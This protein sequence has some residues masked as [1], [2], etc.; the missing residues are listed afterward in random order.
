MSLEELD[1]VLCIAVQDAVARLNKDVRTLTF[2]HTIRTF[3]PRHATFKLYSIVIF[4][5]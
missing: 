4:I 5:P 3:I 2:R 1:K